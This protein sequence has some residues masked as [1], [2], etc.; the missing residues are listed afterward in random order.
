MYDSHGMGGTWMKDVRASQMRFLGIVI[1]LVLLCFA[2]SLLFID[3]I[4]WRFVL[5]SS[6]EEY[7]NRQELQRLSYRWQGDTND[8]LIISKS[9]TYL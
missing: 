9:D 4:G 8:S 6:C 3:S 7:V 5:N 2:S 1:A